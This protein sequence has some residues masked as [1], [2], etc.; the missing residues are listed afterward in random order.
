M[1]LLLV[2]LGGAFGSIARYALGKYIAEH[3]RGT[4]PWGTAL[5]N[6]S[7][8][9]LLGLLHG[10]GAPADAQR[11]L[12]DG[13]LG[14]FTTFSTFFHEGVTL[15]QDNERKNA[16]VYLLGTLALG[17]LGCLAGYFAGRMLL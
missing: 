14:A 7:G 6:V 12:A 15:F 5:V 17:L 2:G 3:S 9:F 10:A 4:I 8:A 13:F 16:A 1:T 11:L